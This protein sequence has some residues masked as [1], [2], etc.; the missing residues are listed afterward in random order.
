M[1]VLV[2]GQGQRLLLTKGAPESVLG[3]C[4]HALAN[5]DAGGSSS[6]SSAAGPASG[7]VV[8]MTEGMRRSLLERM[9]QYGGESP[10]C[11]QQ[12][13]RYVVLSLWFMMSVIVK[14]RWNVC[15]TS[16][17]LGRWTH[18]PAKQPQPLPDSLIILLTTVLLRVL[19]F[20]GAQALRC[21]ALAY[22]PASNDMGSSQLTTADSYYCCFCMSFTCPASVQALRCLGPV[23]TSAQQSN[24]SHSL[25]HSS[26]C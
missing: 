5:A 12:L 11:V 2:E 1:S 26:P 25:P 6:N 18:Q 3:R 10:A 4:S 17:N 8:A 16:K 15:R 14:Q 21:L 13:A 24:S 9:A 22:K 7:E 23:D 19:L 20:T